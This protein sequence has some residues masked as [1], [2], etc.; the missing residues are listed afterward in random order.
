MFI[1]IVEFSRICLRFNFLYKYNL[2]PR[3]R[4]IRGILSRK[5]VIYILYNFFYS[6]SEHRAILNN[7]CSFEFLCDIFEIFPI[8]VGIVQDCKTTSLLVRRT[9]RRSNPAIHRGVLRRI[10]GMTREINA[11]SSIGRARASRFSIY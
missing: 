7:I 9:E 3:F 4:G 5:N 1:S 11:R 2:K 8:I 6:C 10:I